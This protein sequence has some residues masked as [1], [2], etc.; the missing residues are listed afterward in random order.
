LFFYPRFNMNNIIIIGAGFAGL[1]AANKLSKCG[2]GLQITLFDKKDYSGFLPLVPDCIGRGINPELLAHDIAYSCRKL[3]TKFIKEEV[4]SID[5]KSKQISTQASTYNY[6]FLIIASGSQTNFFSNQDAQRYGFTLNS[7]TD[8]RAVINALCENKFDNFIVCGG[9]YTGIEAAANLWLYCKKKGLSKKI[10]IVERSPAIL[11]PLP[12]WMKLYVE[13][14]LKKMRIEVLT[15]SVIEKIEQDKVTISGAGFFTHPMLIWVPGVRT[16]DFIQKLEI[17]KSPQGRI[18]VDEYLRVNQHCFCAGDT[19]FFA[20]NNN[21]LR[22]AVQFA[23]TEGKH[24]AENIVNS[25][26]NIP[27]KKYRPLDLGYIIPM[28]NNKS[29]GRVLGLNVSGMLATF[30]HFSMCIFL[31]KGLKNKIGILNNLIKSWLSVDEGGAK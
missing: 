21:S 6:D 19:V 22:M 16:A 20:K 24:A 15:N 23:M 25:I 26:K 29:C 27:L 1:S 13:E 2:L 30:L 5:F 28:V 14:N 7:V 11:G 31:S 12:D 8:A 9:G 18:A 17:N 3:K 4:N 10:A